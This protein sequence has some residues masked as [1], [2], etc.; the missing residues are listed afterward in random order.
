[1]ILTVFRN[2]TVTDLRE[3]YFFTTQICK[4]EPNFRKE[5]S[6]ESS[7]FKAPLFFNRKENL[8]NKVQDT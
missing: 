8:L 3:T 5:N 4:N 2:Y 6:N 1:M 7:A